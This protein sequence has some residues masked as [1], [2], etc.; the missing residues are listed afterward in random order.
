MKI[1]IIFAVL[2]VMVVIAI[3]GIVGSEHYT[4][5]P[6][7]C[8]LCHTMEKPDD[9]WVRSGHEVVRCVD[10]HAPVEKSSL[11]AKFKDLEQF[12]TD[13]TI[14]LFATYVEA[15]VIQEPAKASLFSCTTS[16]CHQNDK[17]L[18]KKVKFVE[19]LPFTHKPHE[20]Q[21]MEGQILRCGTCHQ[22][23]TTTDKHFEVSKETCYICF[24]VSHILEVYF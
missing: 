14:N 20:N 19:N 24:S 11:K 15:E 5:Q 9:L 16:E 3:A 17:I 4:A 7:F 21:I 13:S 2:F 23:I 6:E 8:G 10:C 22:N 18:D 1:K 12:F